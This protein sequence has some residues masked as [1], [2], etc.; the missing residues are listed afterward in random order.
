MPKF[1]SPPSPSSQP[2]GFQEANQLR[3]D[4]GKQFAGALSQPAVK[5]PATGGAKRGGGSQGR[6]GTLSADSPSANKQSGIIKSVGGGKGSQGA[7]GN[8]ARPGS[9]AVTAN[10]ETRGAGR[11]AAKGKKNPKSPMNQASPFK[12]GNLGASTNTLGKANSVRGPGKPR[13]VTER[14]SR[15]SQVK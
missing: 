6:A 3:R 2:S 11:E 1:P 5:L 7:S 14:G 8:A 10:R 12:G 4:G 15:G 13:R 9:K